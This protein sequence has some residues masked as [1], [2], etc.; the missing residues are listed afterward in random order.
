MRLQLLTDNQA[1]LLMSTI[2][3]GKR[4]GELSGSPIKIISKGEKSSEQ[5]DKTTEMSIITGNPKI[6][7]A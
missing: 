7:S 2:K 3:P 5:K 4:T 6:G 1:H